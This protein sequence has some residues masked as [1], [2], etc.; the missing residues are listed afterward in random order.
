MNRWQFSLRSLFLLVTASAIF[1]VLWR[2]EILQGW[3]LNFIILALAGVYVWLGV[4]LWP[5]IAPARESVP[6]GESRL[7]R[8]GVGCAVLAAVLAAIALIDLAIVKLIQ[9]QSR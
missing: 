9:W 8:Y 3:W 1:A 7:P 5:Q 2:Y 6:L 4:H